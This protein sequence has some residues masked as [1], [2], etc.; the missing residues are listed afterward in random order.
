[1]VPPPTPLPSVKRTGAEDA[2]GEAEGL[3]LGETDARAVG[4]G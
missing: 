1:M 2:D 3:T 4:E